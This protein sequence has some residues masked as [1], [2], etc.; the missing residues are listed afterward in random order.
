MKVTVSF[1][2]DVDAEAWAS[3]Y[4]VTGQA[5]I[6]TDVKAYAQHTVIEQLAAVGVLTEGNTP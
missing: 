6:R 2:V 5:A 1:T 4:G 3:E